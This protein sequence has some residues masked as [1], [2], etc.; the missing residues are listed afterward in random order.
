MD[1]HCRKSQ[2]YPF[3]SDLSFAAV[4]K[5]WETIKGSPSEAPLLFLMNYSIDS[6]VFS[7][8]GESQSSFM[9][10]LNLFSCT[11]L[12]FL[13]SF[14]RLVIYLL[15]SYNFFNLSSL[16]DFLFQD[17]CIK[18]CFYSSKNLTISLILVI[19]ADIAYLLFY[20]SFILLKNTTL[21]L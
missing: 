5:M 13:H 19:S 21:P 16:S 1:L 17:S 14:Y 20:S 2:I 9:T 15:Y 3:R 12:K 10:D 11:S 18:F 4:Y 8:A 7:T 6:M